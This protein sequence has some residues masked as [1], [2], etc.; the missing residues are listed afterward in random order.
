MR[1]ERT[2][3]VLASLAA[4]AAVAAAALGALRGRPEVTLTALARL[5]PG[6]PGTDIGHFGRLT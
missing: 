5:A 4:A 1:A 2:L 6:M 3:G